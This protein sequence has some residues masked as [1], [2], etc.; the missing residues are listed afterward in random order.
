MTSY[1]QTLVQN[2]INKGFDKGFDEGHDKGFDEGRLLNAR[3]AS[4]RSWK[5]N[6]PVQEIAEIQGV[7]TEL[8]QR[9]I[10]EEKSN[11]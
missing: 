2:L 9:W 10:D 8:V 6:M 7:S 3:E 4:L 5:R 1:G 11:F